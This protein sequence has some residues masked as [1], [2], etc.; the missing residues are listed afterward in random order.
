MK[1]LVLIKTFNEFR[2]IPLRAPESV[3]NIDNRCW[4]KHR[5]LFKRLEK[6]KFSV[7]FRV[8]EFLWSEQ[9]MPENVISLAPN[10]TDQHL[11]L[12]VLLNN[13]WVIIDCSNDSKLPDF[14]EWNGKDDCE[15]GVKYTKIL[16]IDESSAVEKFEKNNYETMLPIYIEFHKELNKFLNSIRKK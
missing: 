14:N 2:D 1:N 4:G 10:N 5:R 3:N 9:K 15:I 7:K 13:K 8:C 16:S 11:F 12:E 6:K